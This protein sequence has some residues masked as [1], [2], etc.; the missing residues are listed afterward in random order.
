[1]SMEIYRLYELIRMWET[2]LILTK[3]KDIKKIRISPIVGD[4]IQPMGEGDIYSYIKIYVEKESKYDELILGWDTTHYKDD[5]ERKW[6]EE[7][8]TFSL[9]E[10]IE[11][12]LDD[13]CL[14][15]FWEDYSK[16]IEWKSL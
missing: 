12:S 3:P 9:L 16:Y 7:E 11:D 4:D 2:A 5:E 14:N 8:Q 1:M 13:E 10:F 6:A 15:S